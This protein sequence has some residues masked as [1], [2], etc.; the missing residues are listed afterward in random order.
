MTSLTLPQ[1]GYL[2]RLLV[3]GRLE[4]LAVVLLSSE[5]IRTSLSSLLIRYC[6]L[7]IVDYSVQLPAYSFPLVIVLVCLSV[8]TTDTNSTVGTVGTVGTVSRLR[9]V[10]R[11]TVVT[12]HYLKPLAA[13]MVI[14]GPAMFH[15][16]T[17]EPNIRHNERVPNPLRWTEKPKIAKTRRF[18]VRTAPHSVSVGYIQ[19]VQ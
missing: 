16:L 6:I 14:S 11:R 9:T 3:E 10:R 12:C 2:F 17:F 4:S 18:P 5:L 15:E 13:W 7:Y 8:T 19:Y 1:D